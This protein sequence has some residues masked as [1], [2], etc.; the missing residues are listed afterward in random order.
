MIHDILFKIL[1]PKQW[2]DFQLSGIFKGSPLDIQ[3]GYLHCSTSQQYQKV[4]RKFFANELEVILLHLDVKKI[5]APIKWETSPSSGEAYPHIYGNLLLDAVI[6][7]EK[8]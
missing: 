3:D 8:I 7:A 6:D 1:T 5:S 2:E 4:R